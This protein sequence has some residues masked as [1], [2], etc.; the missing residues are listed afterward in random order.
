MAQFKT[1]KLSSI[2]SIRAGEPLNRIRHTDDPPYIYTVFSSDISDLQLIESPNKLSVLTTS[3][4]IISTMQKKAYLMELNDSNAIASTN[5]IIVT[6]KPELDSEFFLWWFNESNDA[7][8]QKELLKQGSSLTRLSISALKNIAV[9]LLPIERQRQI[10]KF[11][12]TQFSLQQLLE[13][14]ATLSRR[15]TNGLLNQQIAKE[16][17][18]AK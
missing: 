7:A 5:Y 15:L 13:R 16:H 3:D 4:I 11:Y 12:A 6:P 14:K 1:K 10:G 9:P 17:N 18:H 8:R 2:A